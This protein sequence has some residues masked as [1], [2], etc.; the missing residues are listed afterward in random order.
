[1]AYT[2]CI[3]GMILFCLYIHIQA[4]MVKEKCITP[5]KMP[6]PNI[7]GV[8]QLNFHNKLITMVVF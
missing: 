8:L 4:F 2:V 3:H 1:M 6:E 5:E 7:L